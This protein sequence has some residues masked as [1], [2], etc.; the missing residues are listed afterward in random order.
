MA[1]LTIADLHPQIT[2]YPRRY[3]PGTGEFNGCLQVGDDRFELTEPITFCPDDP[4][5]AQAI[6]HLQNVPYDVE[7]RFDPATCC[8]LPGLFQ[9]NNGLPEHMEV[10]IPDDGFISRNFYLVGG[11]LVCTAIMVKDQHALDRQLGYMLEVLSGN[12]TV[13]CT[14]MDTRTC[15]ER[16]HVEMLYN[17][18][19]SGAFKKNEKLQNRLRD[20]ASRLHLWLQLLKQW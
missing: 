17:I 14:K 2:I 12:K 3:T 9:I 20:L 1:D 7:I 18:I 16:K 6:A 5:S 4:A 15:V 8:Q 19:D 11:R 13:V 10:S